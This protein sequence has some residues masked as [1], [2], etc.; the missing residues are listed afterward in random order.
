MSALMYGAGLRIMECAEL[1]VK[2]VDIPGREIRVR[3]G[4]GRKDRV[5]MLPGRAAEPLVEHL[6]RVRAL[7]EEDLARGAGFVALPDALVRKYPGAAKEWRWQWVFPATRTYL[8]AA[9][10]QR[11][12]H[13]LHE[14]VVQR[15]VRAAALAADLCTILDY[16]EL[17][18]AAA[19][20]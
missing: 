16:I 5:T 9:T 8:D 1:C 10:G 15:A 2:D 3:D 13:H 4:K 11:R 12:R 17:D 18:S 7:H 19:T 14:S 20:G 6:R